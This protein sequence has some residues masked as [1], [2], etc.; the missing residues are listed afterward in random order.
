MGFTIGH[1]CLHLSPLLKGLGELV[2]LGTHDKLFEVRTVWEF[3]GWIKGR[4]KK[5]ERCRM[6]DVT[7]NRCG[8]MSATC[9]SIQV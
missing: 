6:V 2:F 3:R 9:A 1:T 5:D 7:A 4:V 8:G